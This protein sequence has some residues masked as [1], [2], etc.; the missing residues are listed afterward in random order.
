MARGWASKSVEAQIES[1]ETAKRSATSES[2]DLQELAWIREK[3]NLMLSRVRV[4]HELESSRNPRYQQLLRKGL[5][6]LDARLA[7]IVQA[8]S[9]RT[10]SS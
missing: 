3:E 10:R 5:A 7:R 8:T 2:V 4:L 6:D 1:T 9:P